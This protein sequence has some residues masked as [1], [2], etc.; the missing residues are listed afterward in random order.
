MYAV[1]Q[2]NSLNRIDVECESNYR[3]DAENEKF[4][5]AE[6]DEYR[7]VRNRHWIK[8]PNRHVFLL[9]RVLVGFHLQGLCIENIK[10]TNKE[11]DH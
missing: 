2:H 5:R 1:N 7:L 4:L 6:I 3:N 10:Q 8:V 9:A 11:K